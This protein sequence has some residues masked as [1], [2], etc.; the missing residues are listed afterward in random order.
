LQTA[1]QCCALDFRTTLRTDKVLMR[2]RTA[3]HRVTASTNACSYPCDGQITDRPGTH[4]KD[5][6]VEFYATPS[7][8]CKV[9]Y[10]RRSWPLWT[11]QYCRSA[12]TS[13]AVPPHGFR[14]KVQSYISIMSTKS[15]CKPGSWDWTS[16]VSC[17]TRAQMTLLQM[18]LY[19]GRNAPSD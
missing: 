11:S 4:C 6:I 9:Q 14:T 18:R 5:G 15:V 1:K 8:C 2:L 3:Q 19:V 16:I 17:K 12:Y 7:M 13:I 10:S